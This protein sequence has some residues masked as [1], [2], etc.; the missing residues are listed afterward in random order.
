MLKS[1]PK[2]NFYGTNPRK[3]HCSP[4][5]W[6]VEPFDAELEIWTLG[7]K[8]GF[9]WALVAANPDS[10]R[11][12]SVLG[13]EGTQYLRAVWH[14]E[15]R[16]IVLAGNLSGGEIEVEV[17]HFI[18]QITGRYDQIDITEYAH[19]VAQVC[20]HLRH[21]QFYD[22]ETRYNNDA[23]EVQTFTDLLGL[24]LATVPP[25]VAW[26]PS[27]PIIRIQRS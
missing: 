13:E 6:N 21:L 5:L 17:S 18:I 3:S 23:G 19:Q 10:K 22:G 20:E 7:Q 2:T 16:T 14:S 8:A 9:A 12:R 25:E 27:S 4:D 24:D 1:I 11:C 26:T 15:P